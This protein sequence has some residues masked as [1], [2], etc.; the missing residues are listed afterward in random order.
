MARD[1]SADQKV[2]KYL[3]EQVT[4]LIRDLKLK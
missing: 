2:Q 4:R 1:A 3:K